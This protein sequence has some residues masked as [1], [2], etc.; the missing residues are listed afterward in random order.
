M[1]SCWGPL[2]DCTFYILLLQPAAVQTFGNDEHAHLS[3]ND[4][5]Y[6]NLRWHIDLMTE[7]F[8]SAHQLTAKLSNRRAQFSVSSLSY[9]A[10]SVQ[11]LCDVVFFFV[12]YFKVSLS[13]S[14][15]S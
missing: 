8:P 11:F 6:G 3:A 12:F 15:L 14:R 1:T 5:L 13:L 2:K 7:F 4:S 9:F 10:A